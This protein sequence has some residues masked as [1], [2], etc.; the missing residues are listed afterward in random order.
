MT[1][2]LIAA[3]A[4][5]NVIGG[6]NQ[7]LW[8][9]PAD[10]TFFKQTTMGKP[11]IMGRKTFESIGK[12]LP[13]RENIIITRNATYKAEGCL[14]V[15]SLQEALSNLTPTNEA[16]VIGGAELYKQAITMADK[17]Y[18]TNVFATFDGD[19]F[20]PAIDTNE[21]VLEKE[22]RHY[23]DEKNKFSYS[24]CTYIKK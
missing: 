11:I 14:V 8:H 12:P 21:W 17:L 4:N 20:F 6:K 10:L 1:L 9:L 5:N 22:E 13:G 3:I 2:S 24:F 15:N 16:F 23:A 7:L 19:A 18:I